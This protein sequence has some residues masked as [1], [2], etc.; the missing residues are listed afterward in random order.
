MLEAIP[1][2]AEIQKK[3]IFKNEKRRNEKM[4]GRKERRVERGGE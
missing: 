1:T 2:Q 4:V 3:E